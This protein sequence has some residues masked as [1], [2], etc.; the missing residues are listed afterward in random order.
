MDKQYTLQLL[1]VIALG[2]ITLVFALCVVIFSPAIVVS[3]IEMMEA[4]KS[5]EKRVH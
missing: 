5:K 3:I 4:K 2:A 1:A